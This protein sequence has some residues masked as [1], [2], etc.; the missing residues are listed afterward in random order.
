MLLH[1]TI[2]ALAAAFFLLL[3]GSYGA[4]AD[5]YEDAVKSA[6]SAWDAAFN[7]KDANALAA[8]YTD[9]AYLLPPNH[10]VFQGRKGVAEFFS[11]LFDGGVTGHKLE[12][13]E[14]HGNGNI[15][16]GAARWSA[17]GK[18]DKG[19]PAT[20]TGVATHVFEKQPDGKLK[21]KLHTFN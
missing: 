4:I 15:V 5:E 18:D 6:Y 9:D 2:L 13:I 20:F 7:S 3:I 14:A 19:Q 21:L 17:S 16:Y 11:G 1:R 8:F 12:I 10:K